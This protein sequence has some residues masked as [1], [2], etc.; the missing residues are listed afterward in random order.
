MKLEEQHLDTLLLS[1]LRYVEK[2]ENLEI[3]KKIF[4]KILQSK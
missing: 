4:N 3:M 1:Y 2:V